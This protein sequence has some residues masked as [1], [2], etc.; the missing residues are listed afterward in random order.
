MPIDITDRYIRIRV[1]NPESFIEGSFVTIELSKEKGI[2]A[3]MGKLRDDPDGRM[4]IQTYLF[5]KEKWTVDKARRWVEEHKAAPCRA[6]C[7][8]ICAIAT[9]PI[10]RAIGLGVIGNGEEGRLLPVEAVVM[11]G[12]GQITI[13]GL[14]GRAMEESARVAISLVRSRITEA[15]RNDFHVHIPEGW[16][17]K[18]GPSAGLAMFL[19]LYSAVTKKPLPRIA[20]TG[21]IDLNGKVL[22]VGGIRAKVEAAW[23]AGLDGVILPIANLPDIPGDVPMPIQHVETVDQALKFLWNQKIMEFSNIAGSKKEEE[24]KM[25]RQKIIEAAGLEP[26]ASDEAIL[27]GIRTMR[28]GLQEKERLLASAPKEGEVQALKNKVS[29]L[30][31]SLKD[32]EEREK[33]A[34]LDALIA[35]GYEEGKIVKATE[36]EF[37][38]LAEKNFEGA[39]KFL[40]KIPPMVPKDRLSLARG[41]N[42]EELGTYGDGTIPVDQ[43]RLA[44][45]NK[46]KAYMKEKGEKD[47]ITALRAVGG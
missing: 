8:M 1:K 16:V 38:A 11:P 33:R 22:A 32:L 29:I 26:T 2:S 5:D 39:E 24:K 14:M 34:R 19:A 4:K 44:L 9:N 30:E 17:E 42:Q 47:Y 35:R 40:A 18:D 15:Q 46:A 41:G 36:E 43:E 7:P 45:H 13:T 31:T 20:V 37:R 12:S 10:G 27:A 25:D 6:V 21:E 28:E 23:H 3:I